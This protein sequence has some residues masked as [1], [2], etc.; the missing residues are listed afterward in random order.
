MKKLLTT[1]CL[2]LGLFTGFAQT[3]YI[4]H[5]VFTFN[6]STR[7][8]GFGSGGGTGRQIQCEVYYPS[9]STT[10]GDNV[11]IAAGQYP[12][13]A[14][15]HGFVMVWSSY[16]NIW[17]DL[18]PQGYVMAFLRT[19][20]G[21]SPVHADYGKDLALVA[22]RMLGEGNNPTC[23]LYNHLTNKSA[24]MG[25]SMGGGS[26]FLACANNTN[27]TT[28]VT[29]AAANTNPSSIAAAQNIT[30]PTLVIAGQN[31]CVAP[32]P[33][34]QDSMYLKTAAACK[35]EVTIK[36]AAHCEFANPNTNCLFG[37]GTCSPQPTISAASQKT[38]ASVY[39]SNW[40]AYFL[41]G[42]C[43]AWNTFND[44]LTLSSAVIGVKSCSITCSTTSLSQ[45]DVNKV[46]S[47]YP[48]PANEAITINL[49]SQIATENCLVEICD[50]LGR[51]VK[52]IA[53]VRSNQVID[54]S[55]LEKG[56]YLI[57]LTGQSGIF[58]RS[59]VKL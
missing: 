1:I 28:M 54:I 42:N 18:V 3:P 5:A 29:F 12:V 55:T 41:K 39:Y 10:G 20:G 34:N 11:P 56:V 14:F 40:L 8:G 23:F 37:E 2:C 13:L 46:F 59:F 43:G 17:T 15:G 30:V 26:S 36:G 19:E 24:I 6:D 51:T 58:K 53:Q 25:H 4:G 9:T 48:N 57:R 35:A 7:T 44:S 16:D 47:L 45:L 49:S 27:V 50:G 38:I 33:A 52:T 32:P 22:D 31:D 21:F